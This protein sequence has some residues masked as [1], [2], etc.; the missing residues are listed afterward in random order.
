MDRDNRPS[1]GDGIADDTV[2]S[3]DGGEGVTHQ[4]VLPQ[5]LPMPRQRVAG[6]DGGIP[7]DTVMDGEVV[8]EQAC[9]TS[10]QICGVAQESVLSDQNPF[11]Y[12][13]V[14]GDVLVLHVSAIQE[15]YE[16]T[17]NTVAAMDGL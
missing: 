1:D 10:F 3:V 13:G 12:D 17:G 4:T 6:E 15:G 5:Y 9:T 2:A 16:A 14:A 11:P 7:H 8:A